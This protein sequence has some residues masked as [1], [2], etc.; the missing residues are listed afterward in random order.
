MAT[1]KQIAANRRNAK[2]S[3]GLKTTEGKAN[4]H[5]N[6]LR[7]AGSPVIRQWEICFRSM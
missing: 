2:L 3:T 7:H 5:L 6:S 1:Q 4:V